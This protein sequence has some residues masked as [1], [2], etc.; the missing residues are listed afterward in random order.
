M[1][2]RPAGR[3]SVG[4]A[5]RVNANEFIRRFKRV[6][7]GEEEPFAKSCYAEEDASALNSRS[8]RL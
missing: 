1:E 8:S 4:S 2:G 3:A 7:F 5:V 6:K